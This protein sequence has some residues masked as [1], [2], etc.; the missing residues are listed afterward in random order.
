MDHVITL[1]DVLK[2]S[3]AV[4]GVFLVLGLIVWFLSSIDFSH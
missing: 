4:G 1:G 3:A 2:V